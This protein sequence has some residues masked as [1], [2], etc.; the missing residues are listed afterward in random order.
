[1]NFLM[2]DGHGD[3]NVTPSTVRLWRPLT[4]WPTAEVHC[5][6]GDRDGLRRDAARGTVVG[7]GHGGVRRRG[8]ERMGVD[9]DDH[10]ARVGDAQ[11]FERAR[12]QV[13]K[14]KGLPALPRCR[15]ESYSE[16]LSVQILHVGPYDAE[17]PTIERMHIRSFP[18][19]GYS[20]P[21]S[22]TRSTCRTRA[23]RRRREAEDDREAAGSS[24]SLERNLFED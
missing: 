24:C 15:L 14:K 5:E 2:I 7:G 17:A 22:T 4:P 8:Q 19:N 18:S 20:P 21:E 10:A 3:P 11:I 9:D 1:M 13:A 16:G 12:A 6:E 23:G